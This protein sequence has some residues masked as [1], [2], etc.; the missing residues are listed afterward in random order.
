MVK[1][2]ELTAHDWRRHAEIK[3]LL[4]FGHPDPY[5]YL[6]FCVRMI[7]ELRREKMDTLVEKLTGVGQ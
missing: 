7:D 3:E 2:A 6:A 1:S 4:K 5:G